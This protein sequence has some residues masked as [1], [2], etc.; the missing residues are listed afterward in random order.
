MENTSKWLANKEEIKEEKPFCKRSTLLLH[1]GY[2]LLLSS[3]VVGYALP[4]QFGIAGSPRFDWRRSFP[5]PIFDISAKQSFSSDW[6]FTRMAFHCFVSSWTLKSGTS[7]GYCP[8][9]DLLSNHSPSE[10]KQHVLSESNTPFTLHC[11][12]LEQ[13]EGDVRFDQ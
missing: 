3:Y 7:V 5:H 13:D 4:P 6:A 11:N 9:R 10:T 12:L 8:P 2:G 1:F